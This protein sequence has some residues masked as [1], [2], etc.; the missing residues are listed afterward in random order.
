MP[1]LLLIT[2]SFEHGK[3]TLCKEVARLARRE[4]WRVRGILS[5]AVFEEERKIAIDLVNISNGER[6]RLAHLAKSTDGG[7]RTIRWIFQ[8][9]VVAWGDAILGD[10]PGEESS[11]AGTAS[12][13]DEMLIVDELGPL[14][15]LRGEGWQNGITSV[16]AGG[17]NLALVV[18][19]PNLLNLA[20]NKWP[21]AEVVEVLTLEQIPQLA[22]N[23]LRSAYGSRDF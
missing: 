2:G 1:K 23:I 15:L 21:Q 9:D 3:T 22:E 10:F 13:T 20:L 6:R 5:P 18:I 14:E 16:D 17:Y 7:L 19:R 11:P 4:G 12:S 8:E